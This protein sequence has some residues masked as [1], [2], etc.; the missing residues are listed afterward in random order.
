MYKY[1]RIDTDVFHN[2]YAHVSRE[3][4]SGVNEVN[5]IYGKR[6]RKRESTVEPTR[7]VAVSIIQ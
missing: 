4:C 5:I 7:S 3:I 2:W 1:K 6:R